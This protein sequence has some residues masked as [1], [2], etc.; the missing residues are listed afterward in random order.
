MNKKSSTGRIGKRFIGQNEKGFIGSIG[1]DLPSLIPLLL[2]LTIFFMAFTYT[3]NVYDARK[4]AFDADLSALTIGRV[5]KS[6][7]Y[8]VGH[9]DFETLCGTLNISKLKYVTGLI[10]VATTL[11]EKQRLDFQN[12]QFIEASTPERPKYLC[13]NVKDLEFNPDL[14]QGRTVSIKVSPIALEE[15]KVVRPVYLVVIAWQ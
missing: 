1:D 11:E 2:A 3:W 8:I 10:E 5:L 14:L 4:A 9:K 12:P 15:N 7:S 6:N 13:T